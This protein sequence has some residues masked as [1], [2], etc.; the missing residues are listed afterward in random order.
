MAQERYRVKWTREETILAF[1][2]YCK[3]S[4]S[5]ISKTNKDI[6]EL[7]ELLG[8][9]PSSVGLKMANLACYDPELKARGIKGMVNASRLDKEIFEEFAN[10]W[11]ELSYQAHLIRAK[12]KHTDIQIVNPHLEMET[13]PDGQYR[14]HEAK[15]RIGQYFFR[16][17]VLNAYNNRC[18]VTGLKMPE[19]LIASH[20]KPWAVS[21][22]KTERTNPKNGLCLNALHDRALDRGL[23]TLDKQYRIILSQKLSDV[24][25]DDISREWFYNYERKEILLPDKFLPGKQFIEYHNDVIFQR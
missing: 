1:D 5:K 8:R 25:M 18:C 3:T 19:L 17:S 24:Q 11:E 23:I 6:I 20:I 15:I 14:E 16:T 12:Y 10:D 22:S 2:L 13:I 21:D 4:F 9:T 7:A